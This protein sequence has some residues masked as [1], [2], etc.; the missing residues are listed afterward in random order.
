MLKRMLGLEMELSWSNASIACH[1]MNYVVACAR[2][3]S[4]QQVEEEV[5]HHPWVSAWDIG[6]K[7]RREGRK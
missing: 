7:G 1:S 5:Q 2:G 3:P 4:T 6:E